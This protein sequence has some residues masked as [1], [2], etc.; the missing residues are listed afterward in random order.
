M[1]PFKLTQILPDPIDII[2]IMRS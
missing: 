2:R 1:S